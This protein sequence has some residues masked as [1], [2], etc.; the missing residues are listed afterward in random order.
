[1]RQYLEAK[2]HEQI[3]RLQYQLSNS[4]LSLRILLRILSVNGRKNRQ[5]SVGLFEIK[6]STSESLFMKL[7]LSLHRR[8]AEILKAISWQLFV[9]RRPSRPLKSGPWSA[10]NYT[11]I[12]LWDY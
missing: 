12:P 7:S 2:Q 4:N 11:Q 9:R 5:I 3:V 1:M 6:F 8:T 10:I